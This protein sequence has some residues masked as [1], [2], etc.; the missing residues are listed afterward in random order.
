MKLLS[1]RTAI[2]GVI[3]VV[4]MSSPR[5]H[6]SSYCPGC[7]AGLV[8][9]AA[10]VGTVGLAI[11]FVHRSHTSLTGCIEQTEHGF[12]MTA[13]DG[14]T[15]ELDNPPSEVKDHKRLSLRGH[16]VKAASRRSFRVDRVS[17]DYG[18]CGT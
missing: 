15:Y 14:K 18:T 3:V 5:S 1:F 2:V 8:G 10:A 4:L 12:S 9:A 16:Q 11:Y 6:A 13:K 17:R 7:V